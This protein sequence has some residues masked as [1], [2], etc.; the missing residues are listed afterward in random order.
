M[1]LPLVCTCPQCSARVAAYI[2]DGS[3]YAMFLDPDG[4]PHALTC[5]GR[6]R[7]AVVGRPCTTPT[8]R[9]DAHGTFIERNEAGVMVCT[10]CKRALPT[11]DAPTRRAKR[12]R[13]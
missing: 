9:T 2:P 10:F 1:S 11:G 5:G 13:G 12:G 3:T 7:A 4:G 6:V 8:G